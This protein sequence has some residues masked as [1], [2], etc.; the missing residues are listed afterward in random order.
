M[1][2]IIDRAVLVALIA[3]VLYFL[4]VQAFKS[5]SIACMLAFGCCA[6]LVRRVFH[7]PRSERMNSAQAAK[8]LE[9][10]AYGPD[11]AARTKIA[12]LLSIEDAQT[13]VYLPRHPAAAITMSD[14][15]S[16]W[17]AHAGQE[18]LL[19]AAPCRADGK[20]RAFAKTLKSP[21]VE[22]ADAQRLIALIRR[23]DL[24]APRVPRLRTLLERLRLAVAVL[25][26]RRSWK[27]NLLFGALLMPVYLL[28]NNPSYLFLGLAA[29]FL[30]GVSLRL[31]RR[32]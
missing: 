5:V 13:L 7:R 11:D 4:F 26:E 25:P 17:K 8:L 10:W 6:V 3:T 19:L 22:L 9:E 27:Q 32:A 29:L 31:R 24:E 16:A 2:R 21:A 18:R 14:V 28:T 12:R 23:S 15:F 1:G 30:A 20:A